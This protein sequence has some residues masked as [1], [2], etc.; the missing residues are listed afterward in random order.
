MSSVVRDRWRA[1][2]AG[3][4]RDRAETAAPSGVGPA[5]PYDPT[6]YSV[7][8]TARRLVRLWREQRRLSLLGFAYAC[9]YSALSLAIP[10]LVARAIDRSIV[11]HRESLAPLLA[12][13][14]VLALARGGVNFLR[15]YATS[16]V[17]VEIEARLRELMYG[18]YLRFPRAFYD[19][20]PTGQVLSRATNDLYPVRYFIGWGMVQ[21]I[22]SAMLI[23]GTGVL[24]VITDPGLA[25][26]SAIPMPLIGYAAW[27][28]GR[29]VA[30][31]SRAVQARKGDLTD[32]ANEAVVGI[33]M[34]QAFGREEI[35]QER[36]AER[37][38]AIR[39]EMIHQAEVE[40][41]HLPPV[42]YLP[43]LSVAV[44]LLVGGRAV[45][46]GSLTYGQL[47]LFIQ[48]LLQI[49]WPLEAMGLILD[50]GQ[51]AL[52]S[53]GRAFAWLEEIPLLPEAPAERAASLPADT[54]V[55][56]TFDD[57]RFS[58]GG[59]SEVL[60]GVRLTVAPDEIVAVCGRTGSGKSTL[61][62][63]LAR[64]YDP[65][66]GAVR[67]AGIDSRELPLQQLRG[68]VAIVTQ[69]PVL[70]SETLRANLLAGR[71]DADEPAM[72]RALELSGLAGFIESLPDG[73][74]TLIGE[75]GVNLSG[76]QRQRVALARALLADA[77]V[78]ILDDPLSAVDTELEREIV[79]GL[80]EGL[81][82]RA[83][84]LAT[85]RLSTLALADR[86]VVLDG[87]KVVEEGVPEM[88]IERDGPF[89]GLFGED[90]V[91][92]AR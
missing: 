38:T 31:I 35:I 67:L 3:R 37:A 28:F 5:E 25:L 20:Q 42:F 68:A 30:P 9:V 63:L 40:A 83:V 41:V 58:Y 29:R 81:G 39:D 23:V 7:G 32:A 11:T 55:S 91:V 45:I 85:Q 70:F 21:A 76:G 60:R 22:Q 17:G 2:R 19:R 49:V 13:I 8:L 12:L 24:L 46:D 27:R 64:H 44:V 80:R 1:R 56:V 73:L 6:P 86:V 10:L 62:S 16:R 51:R 50:L 84:L 90:A 78:V 87:G 69:R 82:G 43:S 74:E 48:L 36:F 61:L 77:P 57:V 89:A 34:V 53:A 75:R 14:V 79:G 33:E 66:A 15:R 71:P 72:A 59:D 52:A 18:A 4:V 65:T 88:L 54:P 92:G 47:A 26:W